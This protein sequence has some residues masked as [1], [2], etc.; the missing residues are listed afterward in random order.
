MQEFFVY[1][2]PE[3]DVPKTVHNP[4]SIKISRLG[5]SLTP[6]AA[7]ADIS[8]TLKD[9]YPGMKNFVIFDGKLSDDDAGK[10]YVAF[11]ITGTSDDV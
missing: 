9:I 1:W 11:D 4:L 7:D 8:E 5:R 6:E 2:H 3:N 10:V